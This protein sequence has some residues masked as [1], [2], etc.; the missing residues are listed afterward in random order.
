[1]FLKTIEKEIKDNVIYHQNIEYDNK[2][3]YIK[4]FF[5]MYKY[6]TMWVFTIN[7]LFLCGFFKKYYNSILFLNSGVVIGSIMIRKRMGSKFLCR[8]YNKQITIKGNLYTFIDFFCHYLLFFI[9]LL[10]G[11]KRKKNEL[12][13]GLP[14][15]IF[16]LLLF[17]T[18]KLYKIQKSI[19]IICFIC[20][21]LIFYYY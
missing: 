6:F 20:L 12:I 5:S 2:L 4:G 9:I 19:A 14:L 3:D 13:L 10:K 16:Y 11:G 8:I 21:S 1:M 7:I 18:N 15:A 17:D